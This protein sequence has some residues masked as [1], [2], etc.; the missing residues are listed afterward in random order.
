MK[1]N[2]GK[3]LERLVQLIEKSISEEAIIEHNVKLPNLLHPGNFRQCDL[4][5]ASGR[6]PRQ[7]VTIVEVQ[8][9]KSK[10]SINDFKGWLGK[11]NDV[12]AQHLICVSRHQFA[13]S[14][15]DEAYASGNRVRLITLQELTEDNIPFRYFGLATK[16]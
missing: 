6:Q 11:L 15:K 12:G 8:D 16:K 2:T 9:R 10:T 3:D 1:K 5:I 4:V 13:K 7:T 14:I